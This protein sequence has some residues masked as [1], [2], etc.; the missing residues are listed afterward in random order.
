[1]KYWTPQVSSDYLLTQTSQ[2]I[3][4]SYTPHVSW[5]WWFSYPQ[6]KT[7]IFTGVQEGDL[8]GVQGGG[9][10]LIVED[11]QEI[12]RLEQLQFRVDH[13]GPWWTNGHELPTKTIGFCWEPLGF[14]WCTG[15]W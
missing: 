5:L 8:Q 13:G 14:G 7:Q 3:L 2:K 11:F 15:Y 1:M 4:A 9:Q 6:W 10:V 12:E